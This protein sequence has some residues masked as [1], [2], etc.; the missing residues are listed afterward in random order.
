[1]RQTDRERHIK[2]TYRQGEWV[3]HTDKR[4]RQKERERHTDKRMRQR[5]EDKVWWSEEVMIFV[6]KEDKH[7]II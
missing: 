6:R 1:M 5:K 4:M 3:K 7:Y 2:K